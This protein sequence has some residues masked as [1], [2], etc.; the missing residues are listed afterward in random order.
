MFCLNLQQFTNLQ[1]KLQPFL[2][3]TISERLNIMY[4]LPVMLKYLE[5]YVSLRT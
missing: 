2:Y 1:F 3:S 4:I 5:V